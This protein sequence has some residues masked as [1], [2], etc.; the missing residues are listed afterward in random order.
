MGGALSLATAALEPDVIDAAAPF[1]GIPGE[2]LCDISKIKCPVQC[3]FGSL[4]SL[5]GFSSPKDVA[6]MEEKFK[7][8]GVDYELFEYEGANHAF[9]NTTSPNYNKD[10]S[11]LAL[12][13][14]CQFMNKSLTP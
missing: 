7:A 10:A 4:D 11:H 6:K 14:L 8:G 12:Q 13:R 3:H 1:Y 5:E 9:T 2:D